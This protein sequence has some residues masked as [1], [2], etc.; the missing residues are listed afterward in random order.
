VGKFRIQTL[1]SQAAAVTVDFE[2]T[3]D[4][5]PFTINDGIS[6]KGSI[7]PILGRG[8]SSNHG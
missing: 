5:H 3:S 2:I 7:A 8:K 4:Q 1:D 6:G